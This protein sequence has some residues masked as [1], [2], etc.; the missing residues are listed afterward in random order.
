MQINKIAHNKAWLGA[1]KSNAL[2]STVNSA[3]IA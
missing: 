3:W 1:D 2:S